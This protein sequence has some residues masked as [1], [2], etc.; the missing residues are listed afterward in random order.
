MQSL[1]TKSSRPRPKS[2][3]TETET[4]LQA[5]LP[6]ATYYCTENKLAERFAILKQPEQIQKRGYSQSQL[7]KS[8]EPKNNVI[9][10]SAKATRRVTRHKRNQKM[11]SHDLV[12]T[13]V[14]KLPE[15]TGDI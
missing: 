10:T 7:I 14:P 5:S 4:M 8:A 3:E 9:K 6:V 12:K 11:P 13:R 15:G 2:F 1:E